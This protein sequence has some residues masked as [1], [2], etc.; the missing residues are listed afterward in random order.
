MVWK[1]QYIL[2]PILY[3][4]PFNRTDLKF[5][6]QNS[7]LNT[8]EKANTYKLTLVCIILCGILFMALESQPSR[9]FAKFRMAWVKAPKCWRIKA[10]RKSHQ[11]TLIFIPEEEK[12]WVHDIWNSTDLILSSLMR[13]FFNI[14]PNFESI[15]ELYFGLFFFF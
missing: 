7:F 11:R 6:A 15:Q 12:T 4:I 8:E 9:L 3:M 10:E 1:A 13:L 5:T 2:I 14:I